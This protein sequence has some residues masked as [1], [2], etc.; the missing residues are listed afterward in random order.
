[1]DLGELA[2]STRQINLELGTPIVNSLS[3]H[4]PTQTTIVTLNSAGPL[5]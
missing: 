4:T 3:A 5:I 1:M 2:R